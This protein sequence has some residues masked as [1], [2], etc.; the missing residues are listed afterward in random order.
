MDKD[1]LT[2]EEK[3]RLDRQHKHSV[4]ISKLKR[5]DIKTIQQLRDKKNQDVENVEE[6][7]ITK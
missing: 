5:M 1:T 4:R 6:I 3:E 2:T 7:A